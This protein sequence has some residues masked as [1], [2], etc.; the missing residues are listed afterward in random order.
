MEPRLLKRLQFFAR[1]EAHGF[2]RRNINLGACAGISSDAGFARFHVENSKTPQFD[3]VTFC[4]SPLHGHEHGFHGSL[5]F[6]LGDA[7][8]GYDLSYDVELD[9]GNLLKTQVLILNYGFFVVKAFLLYY[10][11]SL[12]QRDAGAVLHPARR[13][14]DSNFNRGGV[15]VRQE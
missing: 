11:A 9:Q 12:F 8:A 13:A 15:N 1:L 6:G 4:Q 5:S 2:S 10:D 3:A 7:T 14:S